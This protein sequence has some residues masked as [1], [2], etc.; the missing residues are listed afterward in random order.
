M[1]YNELYK[2]YATLI[3]NK[4]DCYKQLTVLKHGYISKK[5]ISGKKYAY[6]QYRKEG[7]LI[8]KYI[9]DEQLQEVRDELDMRNKLI[10]K[11]HDI[12]ERLK[13]IE[14][15]ASILDIGLSRKLNTLRRCAAMETMPFHEREKS[16]AFGSAMTALEGI[17]ASD[18]TVQNLYSWANGN[19]SFQD[20]FLETLRTYHLGENSYEG[21]IP[22]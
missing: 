1:E 13:K 16:L 15:A 6:H 3:R 17:P 5:T 19:L 7:K 9:K 14:N 10:N 22:L 12:D 21:S 2:E 11:V 4:S 20:S 8:S 18:K